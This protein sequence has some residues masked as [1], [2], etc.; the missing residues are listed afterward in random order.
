MEYPA[1]VP[2]SRYV[3]GGQT[4]EFSLYRRLNSWVATAMAWPVVG[5]RVRDPMAGFFCCRRAMVQNLDLQAIGYKIGL[6]L[7]VKGRPKRVVEVPISFG[8]RHAGDSK[9][10]LSEQFTYMRH[11]LSLYA[12]RLTWWRH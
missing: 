8:Q 10:S 2:I 11:L 1:L 9:M 4:G 6:E 3:P 7:L 12:H 5:R